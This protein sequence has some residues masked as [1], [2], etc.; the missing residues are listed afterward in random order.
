MLQ[1]II[2][3]ESLIEPSTCR[4]VLLNSRVHF[5]Q[6][7]VRGAKMKLKIGVMGSASGKLPKAQKLLAYE[8]GCAIAE[9]DCITVTGACPGFPL[10]AAK[11]ASSK[12]GLVVG[13]SPALSERK[14]IERYHSPIAYHHVLIYTGSG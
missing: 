13:I 7:K 1:I 3:K 12:G 5:T 10:E 2:I 6:K 9:N 11:G 14:H 8:L 4:Q